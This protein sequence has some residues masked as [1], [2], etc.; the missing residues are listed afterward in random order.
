[1]MDNLSLLCIPIALLLGATP[2]A[3]IVARLVGKIDIRDEPDGKI[4]AAAVYRR[5]GLLPFMIVVV[6]DI[7][8][9]ALA[10]LIAQWLLAGP[11]LVM[12]AGAIAIASH[13]WS[14]FLRF[15]GGRGATVIAGVLICICTVPTLIGA[16]VAGLLALMTKNSSS[17]FGIGLLAIT[18]TLFALQWSNIAMPPILIAAPSPAPPITAYHLLIIY[19]LLLGLMMT[20]KALQVKYRPGATLRPGA[21]EVP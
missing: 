20:I 10:V 13:Q 4:S 15:Q 18:A 16:A 6:M 1:M 19:P 7:G 3:F 17:S 9:A 14:I 21:G 2:S 8:K 11:M 12:L 5:V